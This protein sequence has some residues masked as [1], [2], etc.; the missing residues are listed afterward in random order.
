MTYENG[1]HCNTL[2]HTATAMSLHTQRRDIYEWVTL[3]HAATY[4]SLP[5]NTCNTLQHTYAYTSA[6]RHVR[7]RYTASHCNTPRNIWAYNSTLYIW[8][9]HTPTHCNSLQHMR[10]YTAT[11]C[12]TL[13][14]MWAYTSA[15]WH[16]WM[17]YT[18]AHC[19]TLQHIWAYIAT[20]WLRLQHTAS[21]YNIYD[22]TTLLYASS[23]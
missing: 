13:Q 23:L 3:Q 7:M 6:L 5:C 19:N 20:T 9:S 2:Q 4:M 11:H 14:H 10:A 16:T 8:R 15:P 12:N 17:I 18:A 21:R 1:S 22:P